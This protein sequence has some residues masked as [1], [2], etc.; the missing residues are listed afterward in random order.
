[1]AQQVKKR[2]AVNGDF[3]AVI[4]RPAG[5]KSAAGKIDYSKWRIGFNEPD[6]FMDY[7][8]SYPNTEGVSLF[9]YR[10]NPRIDLSLIG[11]RESNIQKGGYGD[12]S[13]YT[14]DAIGEKF[15]RGKYNIRVTDSNRPEGQREVVKSCKYDLNDPELKPPVYDIRT[16]ELAHPDNI[17]EV[18]RLLTAGVLVRDSHGGPRIR[19][20]AD[21]GTPPHSPDANGHHNGA[22]AAGGDMLDRA[23][24]SAVLMELIKR[25][26]T[27]PNTAVQNALNLA[28]TLRPPTAAVDVEAIIERVATR[29][30]RAGADPFADSLTTYERVE[31]FI[32]KFRGPSSPA[33]VVDGDSAAAWAPHLPGILGQVRALIPEV[34]GAFRV[35]R[36]EYSTTG[37]QQQ[38]NGGA[39]QPM[40]M[41][42]R[43][44]QIAR[45][46]FD[47][48]TA[49]VTGFDFAVYVC[50]FHPG[51]REVFTF[52][53][54]NGGAAGLMALV[55]MNPG[56]RALVSDPAKRQQI[57][58]FLMDFFS[59]DAV[60]TASS[61]PTVES[62]AGT[63]E[64]SPSR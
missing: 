30:G 36:A 47:Q 50:N 40:S 38:Q 49:G 51:G 31:G 58:S 46:G 34:V 60:G 21:P 3:G 39:Q 1:M 14:V 56:T 23:T 8:R 53:D 27:D 19:T 5:A 44:E 28:N 2:Q 18:N 37:G 35:I 24:F 33:V 15:G 45:M 16:L 41:D 17:D 63:G 9:V 42:Q 32:N 48:M 62:D 10:L 59:F 29:L 61:L 64:A 11:L 43:I 26:S 4:A 6:R 57:E 22:A 52:L 54:T 7:M 13:L 20:V 55:A 25:G 12:L